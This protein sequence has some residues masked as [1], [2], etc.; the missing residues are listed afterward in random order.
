MNKTIRLALFITFIN[1]TLTV[2]AQTNSFSGW[3]VLSHIQKLSS[4]FNINVDV[5]LR[6][7]NNLDGIRNIL[8]RPGI[9]YN[10]NKTW[11]TGI[12]YG[13]ISTQTDNAAPLKSLLVE[14]MIWEQTVVTSKIN[15]LLLLSRV[16]LEQRFIEQQTQ[17]IFSQ[18]L[19][20]YNKLFIPLSESKELNEGIY[21]ALQDELLFNVQ[22]K[23]NLNTHLFDQNR[24]FV[25]LG[26]HFNEHLSSEIGY[27][28]VAI[29]GKNENMNRHILQLTLLTKLGK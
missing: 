8:I 9:N 26:H 19:R 7:K 27:Q 16:R 24:A 11:S 2:K 20:L 5:Q 18:R 1:L 4:K 17:D 13:Y 10:I 25:G 3:L 14:N 15:K 29:K 6:S 12:G 21:L 23:D 28:M 22:N